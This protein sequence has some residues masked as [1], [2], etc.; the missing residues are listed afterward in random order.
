[1]R[2]PAI[3]HNKLAVK[4]QIVRQIDR[5]IENKGMVGQVD[6]QI[7]V[8]QIVKRIYGEIDKYLDGK[9]GKG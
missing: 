1:M 5:Q 9:L 2:K 8:R 4:R 3:S 7:M 6:N